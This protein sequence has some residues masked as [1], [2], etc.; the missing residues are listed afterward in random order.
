MGTPD[1]ARKCLQR[2][3]EDGHEIAGVY[4]KPDTPKNRGMKMEASE[5]KQYALSVGLPVYQPTR[6]K[7]EQT[8]QTLK[9]LRP[10]LI[11]VVA[12]GRILPQR[13][14]DIAPSTS[15]PACCR[16]CG[17]QARCSGPCCADW[18]PPAQR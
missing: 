8:Y 6:W 9:A 1:I 18:R 14:L 3:V 10:E 16:S 11:V 4:T 2:L 5:V 17:A 7:S 13:V 12:Y 15:T